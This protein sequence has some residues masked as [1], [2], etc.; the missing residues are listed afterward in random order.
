MAPA[1]RA[2]VL[3]LTGTDP[4][5]DMGLHE[6]AVDPSRPAVVIVMPCDLAMART[7]R[8]TR[9]QCS[10]CKTMCWVSGTAPAHAR[11]V[12]LRCAPKLV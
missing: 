7:V 10:M 3:R 11:R 12:C 9:E 8:S 5:N 1:T 6:V 4:V 2:E